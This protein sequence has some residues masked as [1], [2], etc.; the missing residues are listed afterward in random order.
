MKHKSFFLLL[1]ALIVLIPAICVAAQITVGSVSDAVTG[2]D[3]DGLLVIAEYADPD[4]PLIQAVWQHDTPSTGATSLSGSATGFFGEIKAFEL[5]QSL[6]TYDNPWALYNYY[7][8]MKSLTLIGSGIEGL[9]PNI[10]FDLVNYDIPK[11]PQPDYE[12]GFEVSTPGSK[13]GNIQYIYGPTINLALISHNLIDQVLYQ[14]QSTPTPTP[15]LWSGIQ[16]V[17][18]TENN[19]GFS[20]DVPVFAFEL[21][22]DRV[23]AVPIPA[24]YLL[25]GSGILCLIGIKR[26]TR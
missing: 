12:P 10:V 1:G 13:R 26:K 6:D 4:V 21:D 23:S 5:K 2:G 22:T 19:L 7:G 15:D 11:D 25:F 8:P 16:I 24:A 20:E 14:G 17:F 3:M 9:Y 18:G